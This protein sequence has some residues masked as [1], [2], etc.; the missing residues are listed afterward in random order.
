MGAAVHLALNANGVVR[1]QTKFIY[2]TT[3]VFQL[4]SV[5]YFCKGIAMDKV[6]GMLNALD[7]D[8]TPNQGSF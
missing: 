8:L 1:H 3:G 4:N 2:C 5:I 6:K 7:L